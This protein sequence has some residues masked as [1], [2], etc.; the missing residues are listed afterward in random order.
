MSVRIMALVW[1]KFPGGGSAL[2]ALLA[3]ADFGSDAGNNI[4]PSVRTFARKVRLTERQARKLLRQ[5][6]SDEW[7]ATI[8]HSAGGSYQATRRYRINVEKLRATPVAGD[9]PTPVMGD[10]PVVEDPPV[11]GDRDPCRSRPIPL[12]PATPKPLLTVKEPLLLHVDG[13]PSPCPHQEIVDLYHSTLPSLRRV[14]VWNATRQRY[15]KARWCEEPE[16]QQL[17]WWQKFFVYVKKS[18]FLTGRTNG[19]GDRPPFVADLEW[20]IRPTNF[21][22]IIEGKYHHRGSE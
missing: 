7:I 20:L 1:E 5:L 8:S 15:L 2:L 19:N 4:H 14:K 21:V 13:K 6:E 9:T 16:R 22:K 17:D 11:T 12:S 18:N 3:L 10:T